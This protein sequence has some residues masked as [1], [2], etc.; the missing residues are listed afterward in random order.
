MQR[1]R[2]TLLSVSDKGAINAVH[3]SSAVEPKDCQVK[4]RRMAV[5]SA[6]TITELCGA[7]QVHQSVR[8]LTGCARGIVLKSC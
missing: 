7:I 5:L 8:I 4:A 2:G 3:A 1:L 6:L